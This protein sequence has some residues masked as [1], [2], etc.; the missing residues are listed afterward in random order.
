MSNRLLDAAKCVVAMRFKPG[1]QWDELAQSIVDLSDAIDSSND[2]A[3]PQVKDAAPNL[4]AA[5]K[6]SDLSLHAAD[7]RGPCL[8]SQCEFRRAA[9]SAIAE[10]EGKDAHPLT[11]WAVVDEDGYGHIRPT[12][13][14]AEKT[15]ARIA[16]TPFANVTIKKLV[17]VSP[18]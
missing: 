2:D 12:K 10:A 7:Y 9:A 8:C 14:D 5:L 13:E 11:V 6:M 1:G 4:L 3:K 16:T 15:L 17:E 18:V